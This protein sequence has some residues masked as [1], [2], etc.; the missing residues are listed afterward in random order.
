MRKIEIVHH[1]PDYALIID[2]LTV[3]DDIAHLGVAVDIRDWLR[4][5]QDSAAILVDAKRH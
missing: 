3:L 4:D 2:G 5:D 1:E